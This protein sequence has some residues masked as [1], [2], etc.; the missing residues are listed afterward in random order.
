MLKPI[1]LYRNEDSKVAIDLYFDP[2]TP[3]YVSPNTPE[4]KV[5]QLKVFLRVG[6]VPVK[7]YA[8]TNPATD[9]GLVLLDDQVHNRVQVIVTRAESRT[10]PVGQLNYVAHAD[11]VDLHFPE[12][13]REV[14]TGTL[15]VVADNPA[16]SAE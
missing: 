1:T 9:E 4:P 14:F 6:N 3:A 12:G 10:F 11:F 15:G 8:L 2:Y 16:A 13:R 5:S 7:T